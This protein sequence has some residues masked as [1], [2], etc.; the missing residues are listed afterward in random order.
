MGC[1]VNLPNRS[2][3][4]FFENTIVYLSLLGLGSVDE[5]LNLKLSEINTIKQVMKSEDMQKTRFN[6]LGIPTK[7]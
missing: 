7:D 6:L 3:H 4:A 2:Y 5:I 1:L